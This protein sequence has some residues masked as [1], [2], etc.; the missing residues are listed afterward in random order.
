MSPPASPSR[1]HLA[2]QGLRLRLRGSDLWFIA[3]ALL[4]GLIAGG[5]TLL[6][7]GAAHSLQS[8]LFGLDD[9]VRLS[10]LPALGFTALLVLPLG[11][12]L[13]GLVSLAATRLKRPLLDAVEA[14][15]LHGGRMSMRD[16]LIVLTQTM[17]SN[18]FGASVGLE[19]SYTQMG[20]GSGSQLGRAMRLRRNDVRI[21]VG[22]GAAGAIAAAFGAPLAGAF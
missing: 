2:F 17:I 3:L 18:G 11:G 16:N 13:V 5:L 14:N 22:A 8:W 1:L 6:Q 19:A 7:S 12:L 9:D 15:A 4:V 20:A 21:L 10:S